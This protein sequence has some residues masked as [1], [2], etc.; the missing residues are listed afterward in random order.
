MCLKNGGK[1]YNII[2]GMS[3][4]KHL[5]CVQNESIIMK[6]SYKYNEKQPCLISGEVSFADENTCK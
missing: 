5:S 2:V 4:N 1:V 3:L 6:L